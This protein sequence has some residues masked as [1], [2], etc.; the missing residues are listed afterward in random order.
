M[1]GTT[2]IFSF[3]L[4]ISVLSQDEDLVNT[5]PD[6]MMMVSAAAKKEGNGP[7]LK[8]ADCDS[9]EG[10]VCTKQFDPVCGSDGKTYSTE[11]V[12]CQHNRQEKKNVKVARRG[13]CAP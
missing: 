7:E 2:L 6:R 9:F 4:I 1:K 12:L 5:F 13:S 8:E 10:G 11:C 3:L